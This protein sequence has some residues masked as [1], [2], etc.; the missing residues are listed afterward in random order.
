VLRFLD[1]D[2][3]RT[4]VSTELRLRPG[5][6]LVRGDAVQ[7]QQVILN[8]ALNAKAAMADVADGPRRL[9]VETAVGAGNTVEVWVRDT[10]IGVKEEDLEHIFRP[11][12]TTKVAGLGMGLSITRSIVEAH[13]GRIRAEC[14]ADQGLSVR[15]QIPSGAGP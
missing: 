2:L 6:P 4:G 7:I 10:G 8:L 15:V 5:L 13:G 14:N 12:V 11:F 9:T 1:A 3:A